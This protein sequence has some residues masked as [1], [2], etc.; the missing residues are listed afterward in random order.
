LANADALGEV[1]RRHP[2][3]ER[4]VC[5]HLHRPIQ[6]RWAGTVVMT[7]PSTAHQ[8]ALDLRPESPARFA[9]DPP[10]CLLH[11]WEPPIG[12]SPTSQLYR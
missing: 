6:T 4:I 2:Q 12:S 5:G 3:V 9:M 10:A 7:S 8:V 1:I 11:Y